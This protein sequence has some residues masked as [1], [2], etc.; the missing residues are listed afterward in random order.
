MWYQ[1]AT[2]TTQERIYKLN[3]YKFLQNYHFSEKC[4]YVENVQGTFYETF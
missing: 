2:P 3:I 1:Q 4:N